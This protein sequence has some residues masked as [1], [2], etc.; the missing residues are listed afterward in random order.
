MRNVRSPAALIVLL[1]A[2]SP[3]LAQFTVTKEPAFNGVRVTTDLPPS[4]HHRN[5]G[6]QVDGAGLCVYTSFWHAALWQSVKDVYEFRA[7]MERR[8]GGSY[9]E[10]F[11][12]TLASY[13]KSKGVPLPGYVQHTGG[14]VEF[15]KLALKTGRMVCVT[16]CGVDG[17]GRYG[18]EVIAHMVNL[19]YL[20]DQYGCI[21]DNNFPGT[22]LWM[23]AR[24]FVA[25]WTG[26]AT[27]GQPY[28]I[29]RSAV[30]GGWAIVLLGSPPPP[31]PKQPTQSAS[32][33][34]D[35]CGGACQ[36]EPGACPD[37][38]PAPAVA[39]GCRCEECKCADKDK[40]P[41]LCPVTEFVAWRPFQRFRSAPCEG[42]SC[43]GGQCANGQCLD[44]QCANGQ[45]QVGGNPPGYGNPPAGFEWVYFPG[46]QTYGLRQIPPALA[47]AVAQA[48]PPVEIP[49]MKPTTDPF[50][51]GVVSDKIDPDITYRCSGKKCTKAEVYAAMAVSLS[52]DSTR[53][54]LAIV[55]D[56]GFV[57]R[58][59]SDVS[60]LAA[61]LRDNLHLHSYAPGDWP[62]SQFSLLPGVTLRKPAVGR[63]GADSG[64]LDP[65]S[66]SPEK[67][68]S[69]LNPV[70]GII[71][72]PMPPKPD[73]PKPDEPKKPDDKPKEPA[74][75][76]PD[77]S[78]L[79]LAVAALL[80]LL[81]Y[82]FRR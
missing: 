1:V 24:E 68:V 16:Y 45:C 65:V 37:A 13:C 17:S 3:L 58:V 70:L 82:I 40:C 39:A 31:Y 50:P 12:A 22:F 78:G 55:G 75:P 46:L 74:P 15:L 49:P 52:D 35:C 14:D 6:S 47:P 32:M 69:L 48:P 60:R 63:I 73:E 9:P 11:D 81:A 76:A 5:V 79:A 56:A 4:Q 80:A 62:V 43:A 7:Y 8:P 34:C 18:G 71:P 28:R 53:W 20:D 77:K 64:V 26:I 54:N 61:D 66:Y 59:Q 19:V 57:S 21:L 23:P 67:L 27:N 41:G 25:R 72:Q 42:G 36:C 44:G 33:V 51:G 29:R 10:K 2:S 30:G 38:C